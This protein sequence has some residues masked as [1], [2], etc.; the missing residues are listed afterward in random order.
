MAEA[1]EAVH[2]P[3]KDVFH[4]EVDYL[5]A[6]EPFR[7]NYPGVTRLA[8]VRSDSMVF[9]GVSDHRDRDVH[10]FFLTFRNKRITDLSQTIEQLV[11]DDEGEAGFDLVEQIT[12]GEE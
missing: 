7:H 11:G 3:H 12:P 1:I 8:T 9:F 4:T 6:A 10:D 5:P 2:R